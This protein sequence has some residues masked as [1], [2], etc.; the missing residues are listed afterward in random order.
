M[1]VKLLLDA[2][3]AVFASRII[4]LCDNPF[5]PYIQRGLTGAGAEVELHAHLADALAAA[6]PC[7]ALL[8]AL[9]PQPYPVIGAADAVALAGCWPGAVV[10]QY[11]GDLARSA[12]AAAGAQVWPPHAPVEGHMAILPSGVGPEPIVRLQAG[13]LKVAE[14]LLRDEVSSAPG[15]PAHTSWIDRYV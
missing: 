1:A 8:V 13:G 4:L 6:N 7:D 12:L 9:Q 11:W 3:V 10:A 14:V 5:A 2:G 15:A